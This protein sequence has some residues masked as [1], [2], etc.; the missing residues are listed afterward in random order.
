MKG[1]N[2]LHVPTNLNPADTGTREGVISED[3]SPLSTFF[4][5]PEWVAMGLQKAIET[6][7]ISLVRKMCLTKEDKLL[8][9]QGYVS[10][11]EIKN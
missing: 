5:G 7:V 10:H 8:A 6:G 11:I 1:P 4:N 9:A 3:I 2:V